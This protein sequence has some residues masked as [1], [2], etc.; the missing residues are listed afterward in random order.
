MKVKISAGNGGRGCASFY[1]DRKVM[2]GP[3]NGGDGGKGGDVIIKASSGQKLSLNTIDAVYTAR[4]GQSGKPSK[5]KGKDGE[6]IIIEVPLGTIV[7]PYDK[8]SKPVNINDEDDDSD[9]GMEEY[10]YEDETKENP[11]ASLVEDSILRYE[12]ESSTMKEE[13]NI[14]ENIE[15]T[16]V[17]H[18]PFKVSLEKDGDFYVAA[19]GGRGGLGNWRLA[20]VKNRPIN[21]ALPGLPGEQCE[22]LLELKM[23]ADVGLVGYPNAGKSTFLASISRAKPKIGSYPFTTLT[24]QIG[25]VIYD[26]G[27]S[28]TISDLPGLIS[29]AHLNKGL[30]HNFLRY[31]L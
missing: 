12:I 9:L 4:S 24:P 19:R 11:F 22:L 30:G 25:T 18:A 28:I 2:K 13:E 26:D 10:I 16:P 31:I 15:E 14:E 8:E 1:R 27:T 20:N 21:V 3:P 17:I 23:I 6:S 5:S 29:G 7:T